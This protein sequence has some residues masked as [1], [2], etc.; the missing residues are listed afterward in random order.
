MAG[1]E[2]D[3][4]QPADVSV[5]LR[6]LRAIETLM[7]AHVLAARDEAVRDARRL[8]AGVLLLVIA[9]S[10]VFVAV[11]LGHAAAAWW[12]MDEM[13]VSWPAALLAVGGADLVAAVVLGLLARSRLAAPLLRNTRALARR[14]A[15]ALAGQ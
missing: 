13:R 11:L 9:M 14:T 15:A 2:P 1:G 3:G 10:L 8:L 12:V 7:A 6:V 4:R 5:G